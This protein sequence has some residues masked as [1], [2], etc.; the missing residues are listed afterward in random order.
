M[1]KKDFSYLYNLLESIARTPQ[2]QER[3]YQA[4]E[5]YQIVGALD[6]VRAK[7]KE[8]VDNGIVKE[9]SQEE[10]DK[11]LEQA[12]KDSQESVN[13]SKQA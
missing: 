8:G 13:Q 6:L 12:M 1:Y 5:T 4:R 2:F 10:H 11:A 9:V 3:L 7:L